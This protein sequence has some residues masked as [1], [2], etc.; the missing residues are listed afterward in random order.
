MWPFI[1]DFWIV[2]EIQDRPLLYS[3]L[4]F[5]FK[6]FKLKTAHYLVKSVSFSGFWS[7]RKKINIRHLNF[8]QF[9]AF[10]VLSSMQLRFSVI[11][12]PVITAADYYYYY[13]YFNL[14]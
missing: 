10:V 1:Y 7:H 13:Y 8:F 14:S 12:L 11:L 4:S 6:N 9:T 2:L 5:T 3:Q